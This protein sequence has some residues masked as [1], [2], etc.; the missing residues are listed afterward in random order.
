MFYMYFNFVFNL[1]F[2]IFV[3]GQQKQANKQ[4]NNKEPLKY[5]N[6]N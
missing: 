3:T 2:C 4:K 1:I 5:V 6:L